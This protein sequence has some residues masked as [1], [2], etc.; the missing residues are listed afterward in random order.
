M[1]HFRL[2]KFRFRCSAASFLEVV[3]FLNAY[4][5]PFYLLTW[6]RSHICVAALE[7][8]AV[9]TI[10]RYIMLIICKYWNLRSWTLPPIRRLKF[11]EG[12]SSVATLR[13]PGSRSEVRRPTGIEVGT[14]CT[15]LAQF[16]AVSFPV[17]NWW[18][19]EDSVSR[20]AGIHVQCT[21]AV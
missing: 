12:L 6:E 18:W 4:R 13:P 1:R 5:P 14:L 11:C 10:G 7:A 16:R 21:L 17:R 15:T 2:F 20:A 8:M 19:A 3:T 9:I